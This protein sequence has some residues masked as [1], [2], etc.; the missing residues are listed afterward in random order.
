MEIAKKAIAQK[1]GARGLRSIMEGI[2]MDSMF[3][4]PSDGTVRKVIVKK[5]CVTDDKQPELVR[6]IKKDITD[7]PKTGKTNKTA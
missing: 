5:E 2:L 6:D 7:K 4:V 3:N 1:T